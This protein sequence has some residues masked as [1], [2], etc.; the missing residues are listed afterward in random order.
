MNITLKDILLSSLKIL[1]IF[2]MFWIW[3]AVGEH[4]N[5]TK[6]PT[7]KNDFLIIMVACLFFRKSWVPEK[8]ET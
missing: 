5:G 3:D 4:F 6:W 2:I 7:M 1:F 8:K